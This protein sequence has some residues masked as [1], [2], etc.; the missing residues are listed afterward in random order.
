[1]E[2]GLIVA[3]TKFITAK[4]N[5]YLAYPNFAA[6]KAIVSI[7]TVI[8]VGTKIIIVASS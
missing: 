4:M 3:F 5:R 1:M 6:L 8:I 7:I 2:H